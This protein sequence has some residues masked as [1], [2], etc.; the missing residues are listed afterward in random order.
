MMS[1][2]LVDD[3]F[4][5]WQPSL[6]SRSPSPSPYPTP[7]ILS[8]DAHMPH[9]LPVRP[10]AEVCLSASA[11]TLSLGVTHS[12]SP[13]SLSPG[14]QT[15]VGDSPP[16]GS[17]DPV[18]LSYGSSFGG[19]QPA[20]V[21]PESRPP[22]DELIGPLREPLVEHGSGAGG[23]LSDA[24]GDGGPSGQRKVG[25]IPRRRRTS[26]GLLPR[27]HRSA[28][29][30][31]NCKRPSVPL[32]DTFLALSF[33]ERL[34]FLSWLFEQVLEVCISDTPDADGGP[35]AIDIGANTTG[36]NAGLSEAR[37]VIA[38]TRRRSGKPSPVASS[39][40][41]KG[42]PFSQEETDLL[43]TLRVEQRLPWSEVNQ[44]FEKQ[45]P[46]RTWDS[47]KVYWGKRRARREGAHVE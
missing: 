45:F 47:I 19:S 11:G 17:I 31:A 38:R 12:A 8:L 27:R 46:E 6:F 24:V 13:T 39:P 22:N 1:D 35:P 32:R 43:T 41:R 28:I 26:D 5:P 16:I 25:Q 3:R 23:I 20:P 44:H 9:P 37:P 42:K 7:T 34:E 40:S 14:D 36:A 29:M 21:I 18:I 33:C 10:P 2:C 4:R 15:G 30:P